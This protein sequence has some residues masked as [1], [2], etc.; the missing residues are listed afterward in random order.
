MKFQYLGTAAAEGVPAIFCNCENC[1]RTA[2]LGGRNIRTRSQ[3]IIDDTLLIDFPADTYMHYL[4]FKFPLYKVKNCIITHSHEDH[5]YERD[6]IMRK[7][8]FARIEPNNPITFYAAKTGYEMIKKVIDGWNM[9]ESDDAKCIEVTPFNEME[10]DGY[11][12]TAVPA[13]HAPE[14]S[15]VLYI[16]ERDGKSIFYSHDTAIYKDETYEYLK[17]RKKPFSMI[18]LDCDEGCLE[19]V[20]PS[21]LSLWQCIELKEKFEK[22]GISDKNTIFVL[23]HFSHNAKNVVYEDFSK[24]AEKY[25]FLTSYDGMI[26][27]I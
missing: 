2:E 18:S 23:N 8:G 25:G 6:I 10:I 19:H 24:I 21:H 4:K 15:P 5:L 11:S 1:R 26:I 7:T 20:S 14:T 27:N 9:T 12:V 16:I 13:T 3:A 22:D 17:K